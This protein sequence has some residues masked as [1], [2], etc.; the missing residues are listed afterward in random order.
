M[1]RNYDHVPRFYLAAR[2]SHHGAAAGRAIE[3]RRHFVI[4]TRTFPVDDGAPGDESSATRYDDVTLGGIVVEDSRGTRRTGALLAAKLRGAR[5]RRRG[6]S[7]ARICGGA[8][9]HG[10]A[11]N[12]SDAELILTH[13]DHSERI[14]R[15]C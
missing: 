10:S 7:P 8:A 9:F 15:N 2:I 13:I 3:D 4:R 5:C 11:G 1:L 6:V 14:I 12:H